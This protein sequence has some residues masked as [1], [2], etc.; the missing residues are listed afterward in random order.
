LQVSNIAHQADVFQLNTNVNVSRHIAEID[1]LTYLIDNDLQMTAL[2]QKIINTA[3]VQHDQGVITTAEYLHEINAGLIAEQN[4]AMHR[5]MLL[6]EKAN[7]LITL[8]K[9]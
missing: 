3:A 7:Y 2:R 6:A 1:K 4:L 9:I 8:G 5:I